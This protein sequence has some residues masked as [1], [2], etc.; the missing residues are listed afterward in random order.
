M[1]P[2]DTLIPGSFV[3]PAPFLSPCC[4]GR[5]FPGPGIWR[6]GPTPLPPPS[7]PSC[8]SI[9][10]CNRGPPLP[11]GSFPPCAVPGGSVPG[12][13]QELIP[14]VWAFTPSQAPAW[15]AAPAP[16][17]G[18]PFNNPA[19]PCWLSAKAFPSS[20]HSHIPRQVLVYQE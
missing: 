15:L 13:P 18:V 1:L 17:A 3:A 4:P 19:D 5:A 16:T 6:R 14:H 20:F 9:T 2:A 11:S 10:S 7:C 12:I 8:K